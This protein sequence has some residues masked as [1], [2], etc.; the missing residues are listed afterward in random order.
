[1]NARPLFQKAFTRIYYLSYYF[2]A[3]NLKIMQF[4]I[5]CQLGLVKTTYTYIPAY[6]RETLFSW[7]PFEGARWNMHLIL[8][9]KHVWSHS[10][11]Q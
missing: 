1:M 2:S 9:F 6:S 5:A 3:L 11:F 7:I 4:E 8:L 10:V